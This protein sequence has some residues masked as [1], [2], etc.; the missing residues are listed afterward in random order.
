MGLARGRARPATTPFP[1]RAVPAYPG[2]VSPPS[3]AETAATLAAL[4]LDAV[5]EPG[6]LPPGSHMPL[7]RNPLFVGREDD[8]RALARH[9]KAGETA[10]V[11]QGQVGWVEDVWQAPLARLLV[12]DNC[13]KPELLRRWRPTVGGCRVLVTSRRGGWDPGLGVWPLPLGTLP[14]PK[15]V[16]LLRGFRPDLGED[17]ALDEIAAELGDL[18]LALH[19]A[20]SFL[21]CYRHASAG[22]PAKYL[23]QLRHGDLLDHPSLQGRG[24]EASPTDHERHVARTFALSYERLDAADADDGLARARPHYKRALAIRA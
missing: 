16:E 10:A 18:P 9:L 21:A 5:P 11:S 4:P 14:R 12:F 1:G 3:E 23:E 6:A 24:S 2:P 19:L 13:E 20:G 15:S 17:P 8:L 22:R 7:S